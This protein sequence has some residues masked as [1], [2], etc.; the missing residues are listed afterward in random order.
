M[1]EE[2]K[3]TTGQERE[4]PKQPDSNSADVTSKES[5]QKTPESP[6]KTPDISEKKTLERPEEKTPEGPAGK[7]PERPDENS[8]EKPEEPV[9]GRKPMGEGAPLLRRASA[10]EPAGSSKKPV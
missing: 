3:N 6:Q 1:S 2:V 10:R 8:P 9:W 5:P 4:I 7:I